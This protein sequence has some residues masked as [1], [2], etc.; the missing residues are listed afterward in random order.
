M[1][2]LGLFRQSKPNNWLYRKTEAKQKR[3]KAMCVPL[4]SS[5]QRQQRNYKEGYAR[6]EQV[7]ASQEIHKQ[8]YQNRR[9]QHQKQPDQDN[10]N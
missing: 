3:K 5:Y 7:A 4:N 8:R 6:P 10:D 9:N 1:N 2:K